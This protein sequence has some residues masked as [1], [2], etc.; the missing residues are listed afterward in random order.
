MTHKTWAGNIP[1][2]DDYGNR[3]DGEFYDAKSKE[4]PWALMN[5]VSYAI[6]GIGVGQGLG[7]HYK[8]DDAGEY[9]KTEG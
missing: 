1:L 7:Q 9:V 3:I 4:G 2:L 6:H 5:P 8:R